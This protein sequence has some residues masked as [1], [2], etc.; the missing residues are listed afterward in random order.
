MALPALM[1]FSALGHYSNV[2][3]NLNAKTEVM[4]Q[5]KPARSIVVQKMGRHAIFHLSTKERTIMSAHGKMRNGGTTVHGAG[6]QIQ[7][8][9]GAHADRVV[10][11]PVNQQ[12][13]VT[14]T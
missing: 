1:A 2:M 7:V 11:S 10:P 8:G 14:C 5:K 9:S 13:Q 12:T 6:H 3:E 4:R